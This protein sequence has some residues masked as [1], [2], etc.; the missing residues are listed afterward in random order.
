[1]IE[2]NPTAMERCLND[3]FTA[4][5]MFPKREMAAVEF[6]QVRQSFGNVIQ[7]YKAL[8]PDFPSFFSQLSTPVQQ[9]LRSTYAL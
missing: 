3:Y 4:I 6:K 5:A 7:G 8:I 9:K 2:R 1:V